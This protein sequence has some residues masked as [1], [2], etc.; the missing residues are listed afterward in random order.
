MAYPTLTEVYD[1]T[2]AECG[3]TEVPGGQI[4]TNSLLLP[5]VQSATRTLWRGLRNLA[6]PRVQRTFYYTLPANTSVFR[7]STALITD[8]SEPTGPVAQ[9]SGLTSVAVSA[10]T[11]G[12]TSL[13]V[14]C[15]SAHGLATGDTVVLEQLVGLKGANV[16]CT[17]TV[18]S[19][20]QFTANG[21]VT[22]GTYV[23]GGFVV[24]STNEFSGLEYRQSIPT[25]T[26]R[27]S[28]GLS[29]AVYQD[30]YF[31]FLPSND[32]QQIRIT[33]WSSAQV[34]TTGSDEIAFNDCI[35]F[36]AK[37]AGS[38]ACKAQGAND[39]AATLKVESVGPRFDEGIFGGELR[40]LMQA[41]VRERQNLNPYERSP[42][43]FR[44]QGYGLGYPL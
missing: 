1:Q 21:V 27:N 12:A 13:A 6:T 2:R 42:R 35:D 24:T 38:M 9:R 23:S 36:I 33:Y 37:Y 4:Y 22:T 39:R 32:D 25:S 18:T 31:Q 43:P 28:R 8:F 19:S 10:A 41:A 20:T 11:Q 34:P 7:P 26:T 15:S 16:L 29:V 40:Q 5:H 44:E 17:V 3:D 30:N 14:T